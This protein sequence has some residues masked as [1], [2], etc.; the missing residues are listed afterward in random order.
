MQSMIH[1]LDTC[2]GFDWDSG[3][4]EKNW[5]RHR[6]LR[7]ECEDV[8]FNPRVVV[9]DIKHSKQE[10]RYLVLGITNLGRLLFLTVTIRGKK[11]R[12]ISA[13]DMHKKERLKY[14]REIKAAS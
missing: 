12:I 3:N 4:A 8:F 13:R 6:V 11:I 14:E 10:T 7:N 1:P 9:N 2:E 5:L